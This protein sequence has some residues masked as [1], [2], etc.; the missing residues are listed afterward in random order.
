MDTLDGNAK[1]SKNTNRISTS[2]L[3]Q[4]GVGAFYPEHQ[5]LGGVN[6]DL[7]EY[8]LPQDC[9]KIGKIVFRRSARPNA[10]PERAQWAPV[11]WARREFPEILSEIC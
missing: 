10:A 5:T 3:E 11:I 4:V 8:S 2:S 7:A 1:Y 9:A 6:D